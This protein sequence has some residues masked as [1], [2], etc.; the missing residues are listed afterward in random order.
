MYCRIYSFTSILTVS[1]SVFTLVAITW[2]RYKVRAGYWIH[3]LD[4]MGIE[5]N[6]L[7]HSVLV[8]QNCV[9]LNLHINH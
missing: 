6:C 7:F 2:E 1:V 8:L 9:T 3:T 5:P 4:H